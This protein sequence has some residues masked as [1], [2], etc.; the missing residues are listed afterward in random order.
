MTVKVFYIGFELDHNS[1][2]VRGTGLEGTQLRIWVL[3]KIAFL[4]T[5][6]G[7]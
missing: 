5:K 6:Y 3:V 4:R 7:C 2:K 1:D